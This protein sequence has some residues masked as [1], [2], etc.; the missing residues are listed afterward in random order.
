MGTRCVKLVSHVYDENT[1]TTTV[2]RPSAR[3]IKHA[4]LLG[5]L[6]ATL[7]AALV[8]QGLTP[9]QVVRLE[10]VT[11]VAMSP[12]GEQ[13]AYTLQKPRGETDS[14]GPAYVELWVVPAHGGNPRPI[15][16]GPNRV[17]QPGWSPDGS[18]LSFA[19]R[20]G[21]QPATQ[22]YGMPAGG[23]DPRM[24]THSPIG[25]LSYSWSPTGEAIAH[26]AREAVPEHVTARRERGDDAIVA[27]EN[28]R[29]VRLWIETLDS[30]ERR[31]LTAADRTVWNFAWAPDARRLA[32]QTT[33]SPA[34][35]DS[36]MFRE[37]ATVDV[38]GGGLERVVET[39]GKLET[40]AWSPDGSKRAFVGAASTND[41]LAQSVFVVSAEGGAA[42]NRTSD[43]GGSV[44]WLNW[45]DDRTLLF[46]A[47]EGTRTT[48]NRLAVDEGAAQRVAG[49]GTEILSSVRFDANARTFAAVASTS[50]YPN[51]VHV[52]SIRDGAVERVTHHNAWLDGV[53]LAQQETIEWTHPDGTR[54]EGVLLHP[55]NEQPG[56]RY[57]LAILPHGGPEGISRDGWT[58][59]ALYPAQV[60]AARGYAV[61]MPNYRGSAGR[62]VAYA[63]ADHRD[64]G[65]KEFEDV[66][67]GIDHLAERGLVDPERVGSSGTSYGGY[68]SAWAGTRHASR[69]K[70]AITFAGISNWASFTG[71]TDIPYEMS[72]VHWDL[73]WFDNPALA[74]DRSP[75]AHVNE[76]N[77][78]TL[79]AHGAADERVHPEQSQ[80][81]YQTLKIHGVPTGLVVYPREPHGL[82]E[83]AHQLDFMN[84][85]IEWLDRYVKNATPTTE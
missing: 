9:E 61:L 34:I 78:P 18:T 24:L 84:R 7:P 32:V 66:I 55:V 23:G 19:A 37:L 71:T 63:K 67:A 80:E 52:G 75:L 8:A 30:G 12:D 42:R 36:Y 38:T 64:L 54:I 10:S 40:M 41:P 85:V 5:F 83:R 11:S 29:H 28:E 51:E 81:L 26:T 21:R 4:P 59:S 77:S 22:V 20:L 49:G 43:Y 1:M 46:L 48:L 15:V 60:L 2:S 79:V 13:V 82:R 35:D 17:S 72:L 3:R 45:A 58:T 69:F 14:Y 57:P 76:G 33:A 25:V 44:T 56:V 68:F 74:W 50:S 6:L 47:N 27:G 16:R 53:Q 70:A 39:P 73:W 31:A 65:G 62:G